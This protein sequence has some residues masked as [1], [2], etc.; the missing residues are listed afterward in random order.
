MAKLVRALRF[1]V[2][3]PGLR[4][5]DRLHV[6][7]K[8]WGLQSDLRSAATKLLGALVQM[9]MGML[10]KPTKEDGKPVP[11]QTLCYQA[12]SGAWQPHGFPIYS[13][14]E[15]T[16]K[17]GEKKVKNPRAGGGVL[18]AV[19]NDLVMV[20]F[21]TD[22]KDIL[23]GNKQLSTFKNMPI[24]YRAQEICLDEKGGIRLTT[25]S[26]NTEKGEGAK[27]SATQIYVRPRQLDDG[28]MSILRRCISGELKHGS[29]RLSWDQ[30]PGR[31][32]KWM[33]S[34]SWSDE[35]HQMPEPKVGD[36]DLVAA[37]DLGIDHAIWIAYLSR[38]GKPKGFNDVIPFPRQ[39]VRKVEA[40]RVERQERSVFNRDEFG[41][42]EGRGVQRKLRVVQHLSDQIS[43][44][45]DT[46]L[47]QM[48]SAAIEH[49][50]KR[51]ARFLVL[52]DHKDWSVSRLHEKAGEQSR[53][54]AAR[55][56]KS[57]FRWHQGAAR[58]LLESAAEQASILPVIVNP[59]HSSRICSSCGTLW[60][61]TGVYRKKK[62]PE[63][64]QDYGRVEWRRFVC[65]CGA[66]IHADRNACI[67]LGRAGI[68][69]IEEMSQEAAGK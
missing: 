33:L 30:P 62:L 68:S 41:L 48:V 1:E 40:L 9:H 12:M 44:T 61:D 17:K 66:S 50:R 55:I 59:A 51:G 56:R 14:W 8:L 19:A 54:Q 15:G 37:I 32:G 36:S 64:E 23:R 10:Q 6:Y 28:Q 63:G 3:F 57:Y 34:L 29:A 65:S 18:S 43:R 5:T 69:K 58:S 7:E 20:R 22:L 46:M 26:R 39:V 49:I 45:H 13:P 21:K 16:K 67:N 27:D 2:T 24:C 38:D 53:K 31:R 11:L 60:A 35:N 47:K 25:F 4:S 42:R 52:E